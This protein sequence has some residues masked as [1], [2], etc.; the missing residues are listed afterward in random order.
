MKDGKIQSIGF[1]SIYALSKDVPIKAEEKHLD[2]TFLVLRG[3]SRLASFFGDNY[4]FKDGKS[5]KDNDAAM[6]LGSLVLRLSKIIQLN[7]DE[8]SI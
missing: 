2:D 1:E 3:I 8:V 6:F 4:T 7:T 5:F